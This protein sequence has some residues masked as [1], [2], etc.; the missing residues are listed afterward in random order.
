MKKSRLTKAAAEQAAAATEVG[1]HIWDE[2]VEKA[3]A[4]YQEA[5]R[6]AVPAA[7]EAGKRTA[8]FASRRLDRWEPRIRD[9]VSKVPPAVDAATD[10]FTR[11]VLPNLQDALH[12]AAGHVPVVAE[13]VPPAKKKRGVFRTFFK[14]ALIGT[15][16]AGAVAAV[17]H[18]LTPKDDG[19]TAHEPSR[20]YI[21]NN[22]TFATAAKFNEP[23]PAEAPQPTVT[24]EKP[25]DY[26]EGSYVGP[27]PPE[28][29]IIKGNGRSRKY[30]VPGTRGYEL[31]IA[32]VWFNSEEAAEAA[33]F[34]K[35][36]R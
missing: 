18:F 6:K 30:H 4:L 17:R 9:A 3:A 24:E 32:E 2:A 21:N 28:G 26:G 8:D 7:R 34:T 5:Q 25:V 12:K 13:V 27:N 23:T 22:D 14:F 36:Q 10:R 20:A 16:I 35:A 29:Y 19:W 11:E 15:A 33:G 1:R 31:T